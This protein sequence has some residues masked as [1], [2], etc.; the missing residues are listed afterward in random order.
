M[1]KLFILL[2]TVAGLTACKKDNTETVIQRPPLERNYTFSDGVI[3]RNVLE[4]YLS[5]AI[6]QAEILN[7]DGF[8]S[9]GPYPDKADDFRM[10]TNIGAKFIGRALYSWGVES[11]FN[12]PAFLDNAKAMIDQVH[13]TDADVIFQGAIF[14]IITP[15]V[16]NVPVPAWV[17]QEY[18]M[19]V[20]NRNFRYDDMI[21]LQGNGVGMWGTGSVPDISRKETQMYFYHLARRFMEAGIEALHFGQAELMAM[22]DAGNG[23]AGWK[24]LLGRIRNTAKTV[25]HRGTVLCDAHLPGGGLAVD[26]KLL[27]DFVS[28][29]LRA[30]EIG[31]EPQKAEL[32]KFYLDAI[33]GLTKGGTTPSGWECDQS[34]YLVEFDN[35]GMSDQPGTPSVADIFVWGYDE[36][37]WFY[38]QPTAEQNE[39]LEYADKWIARVDPNG[40]IQMPGSRV[41]ALGGGQVTRYRANTESSSCPSGKSQEETIK[42]IWSK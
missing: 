36:I 31:G 20:E 26:G 3:Q 33:Y 19:P 11:R 7:S 4:S 28:F 5:R 22:A 14:E 21:N 16:N 30:K 39:F 1:K 17:F 10:L 25:A 9:D 37:G 29:P 24:D 40:Y 23:Y 8:Y 41:I 2:V 34:P 42:K 32:K 13:Q 27:F 38:R 18:D 6:T 12:G 15:D 35:F